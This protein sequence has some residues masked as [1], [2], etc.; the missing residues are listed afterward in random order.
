MNENRF[1]YVGIK[2]CGHM[3]AAAV[4]T[5][6]YMK[7]NAQ[8]VAKWMRAGLTVERRPVEDVRIQLQFCDCGKKDRGSK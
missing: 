8:E 3:V 2:P 7:H 6:E 4:D 1:C 5:P